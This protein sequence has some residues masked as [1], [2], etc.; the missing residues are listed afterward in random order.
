MNDQI[1]LDIKIESKIIAGG[2]RIVNQKAPGQ[3][4]TIGNDWLKVG[5]DECIPAQGLNI[6]LTTSGQIYVNHTLVFTIDGVDRC[7]L[8]I[9]DHQPTH[10]SWQAAKTD[11]AFIIIDVTFCDGTRKTFYKN[12]SRMEAPESAKA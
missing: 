4:L 5:G 11:R 2:A 12:L 9:S 3:R 6:E 1:V 10:L 8:W 7:L